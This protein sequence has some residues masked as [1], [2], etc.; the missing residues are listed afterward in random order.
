MRHDR[1]VVYVRRADQ[2]VWWNT[3]RPAVT[4]LA[5]DEAPPTHTVPASSFRIHPTLGLLD[6][7]SIRARYP[8]AFVLEADI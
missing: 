1:G 4:P 2:T 7:Q 6:A 3:Q 5:Q 8:K